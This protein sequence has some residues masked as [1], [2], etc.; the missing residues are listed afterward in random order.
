MQSRRFPKQTFISRKQRERR[1]VTAKFARMLNSCSE[2]C[3]SFWRVN[4]RA[5]SR[6]AG[7]IAWTLYQNKDKLPGRLYDFN[8]VIGKHAD[9]LI[10]RVASELGE[11]YGSDSGDAENVDVDE[12]EFDID[13]DAEPAVPGADAVIDA[14]K[15][16]DNETAVDALIEAAI[17]VIE[18]EKGKKS[19]DTALKTVGQAHSKLLSVDLSKA[20]ASTLPGVT[21]HLDA[22]KAVIAGLE[23][24][25]QK[26][27]NP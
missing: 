3:L 26:L 23:A 24:T 7:V 5:R 27:A 22:I 25:L 14:L 21:K 16:D 9:D 15:S 8:A 6:P 1:A 18:L 11:V 2:I 13:L 20:N 12:D 4:P 17:T 19:G 10:D